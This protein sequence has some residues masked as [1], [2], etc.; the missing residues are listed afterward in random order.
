MGADRVAGSPV[1]ARDAVNNMID[2]GLLDTVMAQVESGELALTGDVSSVWMVRAQS[3]RWPF[4]LARYF[5]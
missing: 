5:R 3:V 4:L 1:T 2:A